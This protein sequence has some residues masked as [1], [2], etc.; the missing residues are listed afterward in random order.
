MATK[1]ERQ[2]DFNNIPV[3]NLVLQQLGSDPTDV[4]SKIY[5][6]TATKK[7]RYY[8]G[9]VWGD[10]G[11]GIVPSD[12]SGK[13]EV[14]AVGADYVL[15]LDA[16]DGLLKK[17]LISDFASAGGDMAAATYDPNT[18]AGD[19]F[20]MENMV[21][22]ANNKILSVA[23]RNKL[24]FLTV[25]QGVDLDQM[26]S[27]I[28][29]LANGMTF[30]GDWDASGGSFPSSADTGFL[31]VVNV[32]GTVDGVVFEIGDKLIA[33]TDGASTSTYANNWTK[34]D[35]T[36]AVQ[37]VNGQTG[38]VSLDAG[39][40]AAVTDKNY[41]TD[42]EL[43]ALQSVKGKFS[44]TITGNAALTSFPVTHNFNTRDVKVEVFDNTTFETVLVDV[45]R[46]TV[47]QVTLGFYSAPANLK[48]YRVVIMG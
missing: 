23:E 24:A 10:L 26:E 5:Y 39:D 43:T 28:A 3:L 15:I 18:V 30:Q 35:A 47:N 8:N 45:T 32:G 16:T 40:I 4:E 2:N 11:A 44:A 48:E 19:A 17:A 46:N 1:Y 36:D 9:T 22:G 38:A 25:T 14:T 29:A 13:G 33:T 21:E 27:D 34:T 42:A 7:I 6:N 31:Y 37:T 41:V 12:I 20:D